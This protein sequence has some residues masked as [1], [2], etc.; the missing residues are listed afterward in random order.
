MSD[1]IVSGGHPCAI[2]SFGHGVIEAAA[3]VA[4]IED[5]AALLGRQRRR[6]QPAVLDDIG[7]IAGQVRRAR[8]GMGQDIAGPQQIENLGHQGAGLDAADMNHDAATR[9]G[10]LAGRDR[11]LQ[12]LD[13]VLGDHVLRHAHLRADRDVGILG[14]GLRGRVHIRDVDVRELGDRERREPGIGDVDKGVEAGARL[15]HDE[16]AERGEIVG[17]GIAGRDAGRR[18]L[19]ADEL[20]GR[21]ADRRAVGVDMSV[22]VDET[23][24]HE[25]ARAS[26]TRNARAAGISGSTASTTP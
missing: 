23:R 2:A 13:A 16:A 21:N 17:P 10:L 18:A 20:V 15:R 9:S 7:E 1:E 8:I 4:D 6:Q 3:A 19:M 12:R 25:L 14:D 5:D 26:S 11:P 24:R 22:Q